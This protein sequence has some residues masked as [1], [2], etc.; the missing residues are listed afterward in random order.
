MTGLLL[1]STSLIALLGATLL[2]LARLEPQHRHIGEWGWSHICLAAGLALGVA[3]A[4]ADTQSLH[5]RLQATV[6]TAVIIAS[7]ALQLAGAAHYARRPW[8]WRLL[9]PVF[10]LLLAAILGLALAQQRLGVIAGALILAGGAWL[11]GA[12]L[13]RMG[14]AGERF[15]AACFFA[16]GLVHLSG[17]LLDPLARSVLTHVFGTYVQGVLAM[18]L[19]LLSVRRAHQE[20]ERVN[21]RLRQLYEQ[22]MQGLVVLRDGRAVYANPA[23]LAMFGF[24]GVDQVGAIAPL[25]AA[26]DADAVQARYTALLQRRRGHAAWE[27]ERCRRDGSALY[28][29]GSS[30][31][32]EWEGGPALLELMLDDTERQ[33]ATEALRRQALHDELTDLPNRHAAL[34][35]LA[36]LTRPGGPGFALL[37]ADLD[38]FQ[39]VNESLGHEVGDALLQAI[40]RRLREALPPE[41]LLARLG[42]DQFLLL[43]PGIDDDAAAQLAGQLLLALLTAPFAVGH[44]ALYVHLS[45]GIA[46]FPA[47]GRD[48][49]A[50]LRAA[51]MAMHQAKQLP[52]AAAVI[53]QPAMAASAGS[54]LEIEQALAVAIERGEFQLDYQPKFASGSR[55]LAGFEALVRWQRPGQGRVSPAD[56][57]PAAER[58]GQIVTLGALILR[59]AAGRLRAWQQQGLAVLPVAVNVSPLQ[60]EDAGFADWLLALVREH[61]LAPASIEVEITETA[62]MTHMDRVLPQLARLREAGVGVAFDDFGTGQSSLT[63]LRR[64]PITTL[65]LDRS[66]VDPLPE[67]SAGAIVRAA[68]VLAEALGLTVVAEGVETE[69]QATEVE[70]LGCTHLQGWLL[71]RPL[72]ADAAG[73]LLSA[74]S[75]GH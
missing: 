27:G 15:V 17:P 35:R 59:E 60:F 13:W 3:L 43:Q 24:D 70:R 42:E 10:G 41:A 55:R 48:G 44:R 66:M 73:A 23:A 18:A 21:A 29:R 63:L 38:R 2:V 67:P 32:I 74:P 7:L 54:L 65:K 53:F 72:G 75:S 68:C 26:A 47:H 51:D 36:E 52:G 9:L 69:L 8:S 16:S 37:S 30:S 58:T 19:I 45:V 12:W 20:T 49:A 34:A 25:I 5:Y 11:A 31:Y 1:I 33:R 57:I 62:A 39:L 14:E 40:A 46:R 22:S 61:G 28:L 6:A 64:L 56:F 50:L 71:G 4:P